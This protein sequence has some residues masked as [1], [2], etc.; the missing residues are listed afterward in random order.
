[1]KRVWT[2]GDEV[3]M[4]VKPDTVLARHRQC[5]RLFWTWLIRA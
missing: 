1:M 2:R 3:L 5:F 4:I